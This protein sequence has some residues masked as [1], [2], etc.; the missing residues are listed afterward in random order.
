MGS[1][2]WGVGLS[3]G[4]G[5]RGELEVID[6]VVGVDIGEMLVSAMGGVCHVLKHHLREA[7]AIGRGDLGC[8]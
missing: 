4:G 7:H 8:A 6:E 1:A 5:E 2:V 3:D